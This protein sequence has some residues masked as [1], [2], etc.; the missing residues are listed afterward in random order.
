MWHEARISMR[1]FR[2]V[3]GAAA[4]LAGA[5]VMAPATASAEGGGACRISSADAGVSLGFQ[6]CTVT[7]SAGQW[8]ASA[9]MV[10]QTDV[11]LMA[12]SGEAVCGD[13]TFQISGQRSAERGE[14]TQYRDVRDMMMG[15][16]ERTLVSF[17]PTDAIEAGTERCRLRI[18]G[19]V[20]MTRVT[21]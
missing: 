17:A 3:A 7:Q 14:I 16:G 21:Q 4:V 8:V 15:P 11:Y 20:D 2:R 1:S 6:D 13:A 10:N 12:V 9:K 18:T 19:F 5:F